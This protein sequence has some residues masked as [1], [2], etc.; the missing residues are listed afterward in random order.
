VRLLAA[1]GGLLNRAWVGGGVSWPPG[2]SRAAALLDNPGPFL[3][4]W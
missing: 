4:D 2:S 1:V 3:D